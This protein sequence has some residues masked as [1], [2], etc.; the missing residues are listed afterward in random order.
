MHQNIDYCLLKPQPVGTEE[1]N[2]MDADSSWHY[3]EWFR[4]NRMAKNVIRRTMSEVVRGSIEEPEDAIDFM[5]NIAD[6]YEESEKAEAARLHKE[7]HELKYDGNGSVREHI[8]HKVQL[9]GKLRDLKMGVA[10]AQL[11]HDA[12]WSLPSTFSQLRSTYNALEVKWT[13]NKLI[14]VCVDEENTI[15]GEA[16]PSTAVNL[17]EKPKWKKKNKNK[18]KQTTNFKVSSKPADSKG[19]KSSKVRCFFCKKMGHVKKDC[20]GFKAWM[21]K[22]GDCFPNSVFSLEVNF[23]NVS[24]HTYWLDSGSPIH[25][26]TSLQ[27]II[28]RRAPRTSEQNVCVGNGQRVAVKAI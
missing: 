27:G 1:E 12:L 14:S 3:Y 19:D 28:R 4:T 24:S 13:I 15:R 6:K 8:M 9:N 18:V 11:V 25:I 21:I 20:P 5:A 2:N 16:E 23:L 26:T 17:V 7:F 10:D 22:K